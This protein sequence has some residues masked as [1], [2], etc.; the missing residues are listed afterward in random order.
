[1]TCPGEVRQEACLASAGEGALPTSCFPGWRPG[2][3]TV[4]VSGHDSR[5]PLKDPRAQ[6]RPRGAEVP[7]PG[8]TELVW[9]HRW[10]H[11]SQIT[12]DYHDFRLFS[13]RALLCYVRS[14][15]QGFACEI[16]E[17]IGCRIAENHPP[18][19]AVPWPFASWMRNSIFRALY[20]LVFIPEIDCDLIIHIPQ[21][22]Y[23]LMFS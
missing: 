7:L 10:D 6:G 17:V 16:Q 18:Y 1:M 8:C 14:H 4:W 22:L 11:I 3:G 9:I 2:S 15:Q 21:P 23:P 19:A 13:D 12:S 5:I 20:L